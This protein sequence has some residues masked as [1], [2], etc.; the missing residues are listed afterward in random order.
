MKVDNGWKPQTIS[1][2]SFI[3]DVWQDSEYASKFHLFDDNK[4]F[5]WYSWSKKVS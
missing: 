1:A 4:L 2:N 3:L 5:F